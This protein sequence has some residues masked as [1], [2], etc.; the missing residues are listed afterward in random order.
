MDF[1]LLTKMK[2]GTETNLNIFFKSLWIN[3]INL[4]K[5]VKILF[6]R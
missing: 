6:T 3:K 4:K 5:N 1:W 2:N